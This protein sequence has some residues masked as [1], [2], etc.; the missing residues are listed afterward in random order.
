MLNTNICVQYWYHELVTLICK[1]SKYQ[2]QFTGALL[3]SEYAWWHEAFPDS[4]VTDC[5]AKV[6]VLWNRNMNMDWCYDMNTHRQWLCVFET[7]GTYIYGP[8]STGNPTTCTSITIYYYTISG[9][10]RSQ[11]LLFVRQGTLHQYIFRTWAFIITVAYHLFFI[12]KFILNILHE[13]VNPVFCE[14]YVN[15]CGELSK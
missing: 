9:R 15:A 1:T 14:H 7:T 12:H 13:L 5:G 11:D 6:R 3:L 4:E 8:F 2:A 10:A